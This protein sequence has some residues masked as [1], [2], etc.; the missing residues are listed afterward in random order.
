MF[1]HILDKN[2]S[3]ISSITNSMSS[4]ITCWSS[5]SLAGPL[6]TAL[7][8]PLP[9]HMHPGLILT[10]ET[11]QYRPLR[12][13]GDTLLYQTILVKNIIHFIVTPFKVSP[14]ALVDR[15][16]KIIYILDFYSFVGPSSLF[17]PLAASDTKGRHV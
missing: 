13:H 16:T 4:S 11:V 5:R 8:V 3:S 7:L 12:Q 10:P 15:P 17:L 9:L 6:L 2:F 14:A 1:C